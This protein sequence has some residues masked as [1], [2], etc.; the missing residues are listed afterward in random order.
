MLGIRHPSVA[1]YRTPLLVDW[2]SRRI[3]ILSVSYLLPSNRCTVKKNM[4]ILC[5]VSAL[6]GALCTP[7]SPP[8]LLSAFLSTA[9][10][11]TPPR[12]APPR[13][14][15]RCRL[16]ARGR[17]HPTAV[18]SSTAGT[19]HWRHR[20]RPY[21]QSNAAAHRGPCSRSPTVILLHRD[22]IAGCYICMFQVF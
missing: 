2:K 6:R 8:R 21:C 19:A 7:S 1:P 12:H 13:L 17:T 14:H 22:R 18:V 3:S 15:S 4:V 16:V 11:P 10:A 20:V 5:S 9:A